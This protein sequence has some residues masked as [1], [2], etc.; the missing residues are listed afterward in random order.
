MPPIV[1]RLRAVR[2]ALA[3]RA[4]TWYTGRMKSLLAVVSMVAIPL[5]VFGNEPMTAMEIAA[6]L[7]A[8]AA[9]GE[10]VLLP[11]ADAELVRHAG[12]I[13][14][15]KGDWPEAFLSHAGETI[16]VAV[17]PFNGDY[18]F[19]DESGECFFTL[20]PVL[21]TT[22]NWVAPF[23][24]AEEGTH[25]DDDLYAPWRLVDV[26]TL[27]HAESAESESH[28]ESAEHAE[29]FGRAR[30]PSAPP[31]VTR[32]SSLV[33][34]GA[35]SP[36]TNLCITAFFFTETNLFFTAAWP[37]NEPLPDSVL[38][39]Y[40]STNLLDPRWLFLSS[41]PA[42]TNPVSFAVEQ[43]SLPW[44]VEPAQHVHDAMCVSLTNIVLSPLDGVTVYTN[45]FWSCTTNRAPGE[46][47]FFRLGTRHD[48]DGDGLFDAAEI[49]VHG[50]RPDRLDSDGDGVPDG[51]VS[52]A[53]W[54]NPIWAT[55][56][57]D[58]DFSV[59]I[60]AP[61]DGS[62]ETVFSIDGL[63]IP[64]S[65]T[66]GPWY[67]S[68]P[69]GQVVPCSASTTGSFYILW[70]GTSGGSFWNEPDTFERPFWTSGNIAGYHEDSS[71][72]QIAVPILTVEPDFGGGLRS[73]GSANG[74][75]IGPDGSVCVH[76]S[77]GIQ[78]YTWSLAPAVVAAGRTPTATGAVQLESGNPFID[79]SEASGVLTGSFGFGP[80]WAAS[81][82]ILWGALTN[83]ISAHRCDAT[84]SNPYCSICDACETFDETMFDIALDVSKSLL[85]LKHDNQTTITI[86]RS[87][88]WGDSPPEGTVEIRR[89]GAANEWMTLGSESDLDPWTARIAGHFDLRGIVSC[90]DFALTT[91]VQQIEV[92]FPSGAQIA[93]DP[94]FVSS[95]EWAW[96]LMTTEA[97]E[98]PHAQREYGFCVFLDTFDQ[99]YDCSDIQQGPFIP[100]YGN[101]EIAIDC[102]PVTDPDS[103][104]PTASG[105]RYAV[106]TFHTHPPAA[107]AFEGWSRPTGPSSNDVSNA[108][109]RGIPSVVS[110]YVPLDHCDGEIFGGHNLD[111]E[112]R[113]ILIPAPIRR[114]TP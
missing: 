106:A 61:T 89:S 53:W 94:E 60:V 76:S 110:D 4:F 15:A 84:L 12:T 48:T 44:Y 34:R 10:G 68:L 51:I 80:G 33:T 98:P 58:T 88:P 69:P 93:A 107:Y 18:E 111:A 20:V 91:A 104:S 32:H 67:F 102:D 26:W 41:H 25:P 2:N 9:A 62:A 54:S 24:H 40:G 42:T 52:S 22:E 30:S 16:C 49:L 14:L 29:L 90:G 72:C 27:A 113:R 56:Y 75:H 79:V 17:S 83:V 13:D 11:D 99:V 45:V 63:R 47:G 101:G 55:N 38:D 105:A 114:A 92:Q 77:D 108:T 85:T 103:P 112:H 78:R 100:P 43:A 65:P 86:S 87:G 97:S 7:E 31:F 23:R 71:S 8:R 74:S 21:T 19:F 96:T 1:P 36:A 73:G 82:G 5:R 28:A 35:E 95:A 50:T 6:R 70:A 39:L 64:L 46:C 59:D 57:L 3:T 66:A 81:G 109:T 37:T